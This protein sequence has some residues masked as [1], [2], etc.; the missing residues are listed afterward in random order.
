[1]KVCGINVDRSTMLRR[2]SERGNSGNVRNVQNGSLAN[3]F[4]NSS[5]FGR[6]ETLEVQKEN[7]FAK[8]GGRHKFNGNLS[9]HK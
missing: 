2:T 3:L 8:V 7:I 6:L 5:I 1:M 9:R 4:N